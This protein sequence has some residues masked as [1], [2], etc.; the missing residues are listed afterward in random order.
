MANA[1]FNKKEEIVRFCPKCHSIDISAIGTFESM[2]GG[3]VP[4]FRCNNCN[5]IS[6]VFPQAKISDLQKL[7]KEDEK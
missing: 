6:Q 5:Y 3:G 2:L 7:K 4:T 1:L